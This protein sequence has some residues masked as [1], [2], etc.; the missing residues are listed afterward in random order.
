MLAKLVY[1]LVDTIN[2]KQLRSFISYVS[3]E[4]RFDELKV[5]E[6]AKRVFYIVLHSRMEN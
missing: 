5:L 3:V 1:L 6:F 4:E 2:F